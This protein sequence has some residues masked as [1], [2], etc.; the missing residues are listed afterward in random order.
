MFG[1]FFFFFFENRAFYEKMR[2]KYCRAGQATVESMAHAH[3]MLDTRGYKYTHTQVVYYSLLFHS[4]NGCT[5]VPHCYVTRA[6]PVLLGFWKM[7]ENFN[8]IL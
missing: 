6:L 1:N 2:E 3:C 5:N 4:N 8:G 7:Y